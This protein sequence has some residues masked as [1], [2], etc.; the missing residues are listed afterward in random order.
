MKE[1][2]FTLGGR[3]SL[4]ARVQIALVAKALQK[5]KAEIK[6]DF[7]C[8]KTDADQD[9][10]TPL[11]KMPS[12]GKG[13][14]SSVFSSLLL[15]GRA[16]IIIHSHK[17]LALEGHPE[18]EIIPVLKRADQRD[19][20]LFKKKAIGKIPKK[21]VLLTS[22]LRRAFLL[23]HFLKKALPAPMQSSSLV[24]EAIRGNV[25]TRIKKLSQSTAHALVIAKAA[26]DRLL[27]TPDHLLLDPRL[28]DPDELLKEQEEIR[29][30][31]E[32]CTFM[33]LPLSWCPNAPAQ[34]SLAAEIRKTDKEVKKLVN[35]LQDPVNTH[36]SIGERKNLS[37]FGGGC[38]QKI[39]IAYIERDY[40]S[41]QYLR[42]ENE[43]AQ[44][45]WEKN[46]QA[47]V[48]SRQNRKI[49][50]VSK[51]IKKIWPLPEESL[52]IKRTSLASSLSAAAPKY[53]WVS[54]KEAWP[55]KWKTEAENIIW[56]AGV[57]SLFS[58]AERGLW[59]HGC[60]DALGEEEVGIE[61]IVPALGQKIDF[62]KL[63]HQ[64]RIVDSRW[65]TLST[66]QI[67][68]YT[69]IPD[70]RER[71][72][73]FWKSASQFEWVTRIYPEILKA[74]HACG[75]GLSYKHIQKKALGPV[76]IYL[77]Y[78]SWLDEMLTK[79]KKTQ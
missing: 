43:I 47:K 35:S 20:L 45:M 57:Q 71:T 59:V 17:D 75:P 7:L 29:K 58:L 52:K 21:I 33:V 37:Y 54:R 25:T 3:Q 36:T 49:Q 1:R 69:K 6:F 15:E 16:D 51:G 11:W 55:D 22:S 39:G 62:V 28:L 30:I 12:E 70:L 19:I 65:D 50:K 44:L 72:H 66:Y 8:K 56:T 41:I 38:H 73:F 27:I 5:K 2:R 10:S 13:V 67:E 23:K 24:F 46:F 78:Q 14:F 4:L 9:L 79:D 26:L 64:K 31:L 42:G 32:E 61:S 53:A 63:S 48:K 74:H 77:D 18:T 68:L 60:A 34:G 40:A 76:S